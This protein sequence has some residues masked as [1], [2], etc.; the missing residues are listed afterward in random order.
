MRLRAPCTGAQSAEPSQTARA[1]SQTPL[2]ARLAR[3][4]NP[5]PLGSDHLQAAYQHRHRQSQTTPVD[6][7]PFYD[8]S[9]PPRARPRRRARSPCRSPSVV[10]SSAMHPSAHDRIPPA[11]ATR[12][13]WGSRPV[14]AQIPDPLPSRASTAVPPVHHTSRAPS[15]VLRAA[16]AAPAPQR[17]GAGPTP[18]EPL[19]ASLLSASGLYS[20][21]CAPAGAATG[22]GATA[23]LGGAVA[24]AYAE[25]T[26]I[27]DAHTNWSVSTKS[28]RTT[29]MRV[30]RM[31]EHAVVKFFRM[32]SPYLMTAAT[33]SPPASQRGAGGGGRLSWRL[34]GRLSG[35]AGTRAHR[36]R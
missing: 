19:P 13:G 24:Y 4:H 22:C 16:A 15:S 33:S 20:S 35:H 8:R 26:T 17:H 6:A 29:E 32:L 36:T 1:R 9:Q 30:P 31:T 12:R 10:P 14:P 3:I 23:V 7:R 25:A 27:P 5:P 11:P 2:D 34:S 18:S 21:A 28:K